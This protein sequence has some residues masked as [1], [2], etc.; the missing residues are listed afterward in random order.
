MGKFLDIARTILLQEGRP[1]RV[2]DIIE[3]AQEKGYMDFSGGNTPHQTIKARIS[4]DI[5][6]KKEKSFFK[7][8]AK[9]VFILREQD[10]KEY[11]AIP[12]IKRIKEDEKVLVIKTAS[13]ESIGLFDGVRTGYKKYLD[14]VLSKKNTFFLSR[15]SAEKD[16]THKQILSYILIERNGKILRFVRGVYTNAHTMLRG[17]FCIGFGGHVQDYDVDLFEFLY[18]DNGY[19]NSVKRE[20]L[21]E[22]K[23]P[24]NRITPK[25]LQII[26]VLNDDSSEVGKSH[27]AILHK[28]NLNNL[29]I[30]DV[31]KLK[32][33]KSIN[34][35][36]FIP[37][38]ELGNDFEKYE[39]WSKLCIKTFFKDYVS[40]DC[41]IHR[42]K[43]YSLSRHP[44]VIVF[45]GS[46]GS[47]K[48][49]ASR[50][51]EKDFGYT[52]ISS[53]K[54]LQE[55]MGSPSLAKIGRHQ[56]QNLAYSFI[57]NQNGPTTLANK[58]LDLINVKPDLKYVVDGIRNIKTFNILKSSLGKDCSLIFVES[59]PDNCFKFYQKREGTL[60][61]S[62]FFDYINHPVEQD[63]KP[64]LG[65][66]NIVVYN[67]GSLLSFQSQIKKFFKSEIAK[68]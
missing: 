36:S 4:E 30:S 59:T 25:S 40:I 10:G 35:L 39:Y 41:K 7:R 1:L 43:N 34:Q 22:L 23:I 42:V 5:K 62:T 56:F 57:S 38:N 8:V 68:L 14:L 52:F 61:T 33:E 6:R 45:V 28:L 51:L 24:E 37:I 12:F 53:G 15:L 16:I 18:N 58:I 67:H 19:F 66:A 54:I 55:L 49:E 17:S 20:L 50:I 21:E 60:A 47:G 29:K 13:I 11:D 26:G 32:G 3:L 2:N 9:G 31:K 46:I 48:T 63:I 64:I 27:F 44:K 65:K